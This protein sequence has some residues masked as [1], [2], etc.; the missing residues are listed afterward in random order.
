MTY[1]ELEKYF[2]EHKGTGFLATADAKAVVNGAVYARPHFTGDDE[3]AFIMSDRKT[4]ANVL[5]NPSAAYVFVQDGSKSKGV[6]LYLH[7]LREVED[8]GLVEVLRRSYHGSEKHEQDERK[9]VVYF[10]LDSML[11]LVGSEHH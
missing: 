6:R 8:S 10:R 5:E 9:F 2:E 1:E 11:P 4:H 3:I 7:F